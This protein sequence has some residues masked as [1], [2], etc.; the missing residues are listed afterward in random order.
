[1]PA[2]RH[3]IGMAKTASVVKARG[4]GAVA[5]RPMITATSER[6]SAVV[7]HPAITKMIA[8]R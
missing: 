4:S 7:G 1:M 3:A 8:M 2:S 5:L 6:Q